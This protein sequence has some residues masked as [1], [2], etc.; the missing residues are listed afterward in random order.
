MM[1]A[2]VQLVGVTPKPQPGHIA[3]SGI[4]T[5]VQP[6]DAP[7]AVYENGRAWHARVLQ[8]H[9]LT[10]GARFSGPAI[11]EQYDTTTY[12]PEGFEVHVDRWLNLIG[13]KHA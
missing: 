11:V 2:R 10:P 7:R 6:E 13:D 5:R 8:R 12:V 1:T 4:A 9:A 3:S